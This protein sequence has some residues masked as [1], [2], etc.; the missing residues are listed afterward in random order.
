M[1]LDDTKKRSGFHRQSQQNKLMKIIEI[2]GTSCETF[3]EGSI[4]QFQ[5][6]PSTKFSSSSASTQIKYI[7]SLTYLI[8]L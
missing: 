2:N 8:R 6:E 7:V 5:P 4:Y 3:N 1:E